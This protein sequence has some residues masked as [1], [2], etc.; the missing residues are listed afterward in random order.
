[1]LESNTTVDILQVVFLY[2]YLKEEISH[3]YPKFFFVVII[4]RS[5]VIDNPIADRIGSAITCEDFPFTVGY[6]NWNE[7][8]N[9]NYLSHYFQHIY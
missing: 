4:D 5:L 3:R 1:M 7:E 6:N 2:F 8:F 9:F